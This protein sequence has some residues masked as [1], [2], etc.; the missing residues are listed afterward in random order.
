MRCIIDLMSQEDLGNLGFE[1]TL[2]QLDEDGN[3]TGKTVG[4][5]DAHRNGLWHES[6]HVWIFDRE[7]K[8]LLQRRGPKVFFAGRLDISAA[9]HVKSGE[10]PRS[11]AKAELSEELGIDASDD[12]LYKAGVMKVQEYDEESGWTNNEFDH[13]FLMLVDDSSQISTDGEVDEVIW[14]D[15][16]QLLFEL[17]DELATQKYVPHGE[18]YQF[19]LSLI[20]QRLVQLGIKAQTLRPESEL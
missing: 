8:I 17:N 1:E 12:Q 14:I 11:A 20:R 9:G 3:K 15:E 18:Y 7:G 13:V 10:T 16:E 19:A 6:S 2:D 5:F 4:Y